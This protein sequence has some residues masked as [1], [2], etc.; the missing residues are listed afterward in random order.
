MKYLTNFRNYMYVAN[1]E[2]HVIHKFQELREI[3]DYAYFL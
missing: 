2:L 1:K 3:P